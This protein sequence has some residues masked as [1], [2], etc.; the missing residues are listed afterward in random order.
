MAT[1]TTIYGTALQMAAAD[2]LADVLGASSRSAAI[3]RAVEF[4]LE[5][6]TGSP[7]RLLAEANVVLDPSIVVQ[8]ERGEDGAARRV[9]VRCPEAA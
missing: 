6:K 7:L 4:M 2:R 3:W 9:V 1:R 8:V 5:I